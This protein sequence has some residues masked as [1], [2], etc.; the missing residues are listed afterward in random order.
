MLNIKTSL[1]C[2][3][4]HL[5]LSSVPGLEDEVSNTSV[6]NGSV[7]Q[8]LVDPQAT[9]VSPNVEVKWFF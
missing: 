1:V 3:V 7:S 5:Q 2:D 9:N 6:M 8:T 4:S